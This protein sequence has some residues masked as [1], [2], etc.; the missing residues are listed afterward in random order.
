MRVIFMSLQ[1]AA[2]NHNVVS[3]YVAPSSAQFVRSIYL[4]GQKKINERIKDLFETHINIRSSS[5]EYEKEPFWDTFDPT[6][7]RTDDE[8]IAS[9]KARKEKEENWS[10]SIMASRNDTRYKLDNREPPL[11]IYL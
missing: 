9:H 8:I 7:I 6:L 11:K 1:F 5:N 2:F 10:K 4:N 3:T